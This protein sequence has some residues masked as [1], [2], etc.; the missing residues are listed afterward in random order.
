MHRLNVLPISA[1]L[2]DL[3]ENASIVT[4]LGVYLA[5]PTVVACLSTICTI[6]K[7]IFL[8]ASILLAVVGLAKAATSGFRKK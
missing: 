5:Q 2:F 1:G 4:L 8:G 3:L 6:S 7:T